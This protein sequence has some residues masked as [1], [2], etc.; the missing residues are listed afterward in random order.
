[1]SNVSSQKS[2]NKALLSTLGAPSERSWVA[3]ARS[4]RYTVI[5][6]GGTVEYSVGCEGLG[7]GLEKAHE[8]SIGGGD[9][10]L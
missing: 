7:A 2:L 5:H 8:G 6:R 1:M 10:A 9:V 4:D 3:S